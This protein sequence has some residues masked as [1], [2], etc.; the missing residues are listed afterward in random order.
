MRYVSTRGNTP[1]MAFQDAVIT[2]LAPD[3]GLLVPAEIPNV[4]ARLDDWCGLDFTRLAYEVMGC[5]IDDIPPEEL[6]ALVERS[7]ASFDH[8][9]VAPLV[10]LGETQILELFHGPT[11]AFKDV[12][13][14][15]LGQ[16]FD[17]IL[18]QRD[19]QLNILGA[20][21][22]DTGSAA[23]AGVRGKHNV[24][25]AVMFPRGR[26][27]PL[28]QLQMTTIADS[29]VHCLSID[30]SFDDCQTIMKSAF[31]DLGFKGKHHLGAVNSVN[32]ARVL[33][34]VVYYVYV[35]LKCDKGD[36]VDV[37]VPTGNFGNIFAAFI[38]RQMG[39]PLRQLLLGTNENN[40]L[41]EFFNSGSYARGAVHHTISPSMDI[42]VASNFERFLYFAY[43]RDGA[44]VCDFMS[45]FAAEGAASMALDALRDQPI[46]ATAVD[47]ATTLAAIQRVYKQHDY[48][49]D[50]HTAVGVAAADF[51]VPVAQRKRPLVCVA[52]AHPAKFP[53]AIEEALPGVVPTHPRLDSLKDLPERVIELPATDTA[54]RDYV[55]ANMAL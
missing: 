7:Y 30:G 28:Q 52:T 5:F 37:S 4:S 32:W 55:A 14:Q 46:S 54:V 10:D 8:P 33:A 1:P 45:A 26:V 42:Q 22:G 18:G 17:Y 27:S 23:I 35:A 53:A 16:L 49:L 2:G 3:G 29:N 6:R 40:I 36:G 47:T 38:A 13:L 50:P 11:L 44:R 9:E 20:T 15:F 19:G 51:L 12:A 21:S 39:V 24:N 43:A 31:A 34:Q 25:I 48:L 41:S